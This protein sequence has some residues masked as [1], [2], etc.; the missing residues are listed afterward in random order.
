[1]DDVLRQNR[2][3]ARLP[4]SDVAEFS[5]QL[6]AVDVPRGYLIR[7][8]DDPAVWV[9]FPVAGL[10][11]VVGRDRTGAGVD[12]AVVGRDGVVDAHAALVDVPM[13]TEV[14]QQIPGSALRI[15]ASGFRD[16]VASRPSLRHVVDLYLAALFVEVAQGSA[17]NRLHPLQARIARWLL[18]TSEHV[19]S[20]RFALTH[21]LLALMV[22]SSRPKV[23][24]RLGEM[25]EAEIIGLGRKEV[26]LLDAEALE[27]QACDCH[28]AI[29]ETRDR[30]FKE[31]VPGRSEAP[32]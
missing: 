18:L 27:A 20:D 25:A 12:V 22:G 24:E 7:G 29:T 23:T 9:Y 5:A 1:M 4:D 26:R 31:P 14:L 17:C 21:E 13:P 30:I 19:G 15:R 3:L 8:Q 32:S 6:E 2:L 10:V 28:R 11:S 16:A